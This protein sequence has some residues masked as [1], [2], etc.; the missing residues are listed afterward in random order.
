MYIVDGIEYSGDIS[1]IN[2]N[3]I[4][5]MS[6]RK[7][8]EEI[9]K[10]GEKAKNGVIHIVTKNKK[11][12]QSVQTVY[13]PEKRER[14]TSIIFTDIKGRFGTYSVTMQ[15]ATQKKPLYIVNGIMHSSN[16]LHNIISE[17]VK[18]MV[19]MESREAKAKYGAKAK[20]GIVIITTKSKK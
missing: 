12:V 19:M 14:T 2:A 17:D 15:N 6:I 4:A 1:N 20:N 3:D 11:I 13:D 10:Y 18:S 5:S 8:S 7:D 16:E 9:A